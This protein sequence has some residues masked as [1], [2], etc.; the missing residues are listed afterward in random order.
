MNKVQDTHD[1]THAYQSHIQNWSRR[2]GSDV[3]ESLSTIQTKL[4]SSYLDLYS[5]FTFSGI[6]HLLSE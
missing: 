6:F 5:F 2:N 1:G 4:F 3:P